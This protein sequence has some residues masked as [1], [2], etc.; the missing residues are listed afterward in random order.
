MLNVMHFNYVFVTTNPD[1]EGPT[2][3]KWSLYGKK[4]LDIR[5][6]VVGL[7][8]EKGVEAQCDGF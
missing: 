1:L 5:L 7:T 2:H 3:A 8:E 4:E 6:F